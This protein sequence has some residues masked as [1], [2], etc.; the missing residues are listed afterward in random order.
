MSV[1]QV[2]SR[3]DRPCAVIVTVLSF[4]WFASHSFAANN[5]AFDT[6]SKSV[7]VDGTLEV[8]VNINTDDGVHVIGADIWMTVDESYLEV[9]SINP[10]S[11]FPTVTGQ[12]LPGGKIYMA[13]ILEDTTS[14]L[15]GDGNVGTIL[16]TPKKTGTTQIRFDCQGNNV[17]DTSKININFANPQNVIDCSSTSANVLSV[18]VSATGVEA[19]PTPEGGTEPTATPAVYVPGGGTSTSLTPAPTGLPESG[20]F[21]HTVYYVVSGGVLV[22]LAGIMRRVYVGL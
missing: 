8:P 15:T 2:I 1:R 11:F 10:G 17:S 16:F 13:G 5:F 4:L 19:T 3:W 6:T 21:D 7:S 20:F 9:Q 18:T 22:L 12:R 14:T